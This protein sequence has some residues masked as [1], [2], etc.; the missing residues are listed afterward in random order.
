MAL[1]ETACASGETTRRRIGL[2]MPLN[3]LPLL[4]FDA[5]GAGWARRNI[6]T[7]GV[8]SMSQGVNWFVNALEDYVR[9]PQLDSGSATIRC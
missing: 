6:D 7:M 4:A 3:G 2:A 1:G 9:H 8:Y 5:L